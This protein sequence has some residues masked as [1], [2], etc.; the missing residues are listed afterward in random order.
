[1]N[2]ITSETFSLMQAGKPYKSYIKTILGQVYL[3]VLN[4]F[5]EQP[6]GRIVQG[7]P[8]TS[9]KEDCIVDVWSEKEDMYF[10]R[11]NK[12]H[13]ETGTIIQYERKPQEPKPKEVKEYS[14]EE[15][16]VLLNSK[17]IALQSAVNKL[18][19]IPPVYR[20]LTLAKEEEKS[21]KY[22]KFLEGKLSELQ[23]SE[24]PEETNEV[25]TL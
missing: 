13:F 25:E 24:Y 10:K 4:P 3:K 15:L 23:K 16:K 1:M 22:I 7:N 8:S 9:D 2:S 17:F 20:L 14:D 6:E 11:A 18:D 21:E 19:T 12:R 5:S